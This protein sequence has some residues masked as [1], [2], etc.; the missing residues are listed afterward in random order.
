MAVFLY[1]VCFALIFLCG[2]GLPFAA[3]RMST[4]LVFLA[5]SIVLFFGGLW[6]SDLARE[7]PPLNFLAVLC[8]SVLPF[9]AGALARV[10]TLAFFANKEKE[11]VYVLGV[12]AVTTVL[13]FGVGWVTFGLTA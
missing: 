5:A 8:L 9:A 11:W 1:V 4:A 3:K 7:G 13:W 12:G 2:F 6:L 10:I